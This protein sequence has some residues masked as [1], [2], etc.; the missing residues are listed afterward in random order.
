MYCTVAAI[1]NFSNFLVIFDRT[2][3]KYNNDFVITEGRANC[4]MKEI[5]ITEVGTV[6]TMK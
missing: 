3:K 6:Y 2:G 5:V 1:L 4:M